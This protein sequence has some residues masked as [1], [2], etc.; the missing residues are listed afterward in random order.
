MTPLRS[1]SRSGGVVC[2]ISMKAFVLSLFLLT[3]VGGA[4]TQESDCFYYYNPA[5][6]V[7]YRIPSTSSLCTNS[8][9]AFQDW[10]SNGRRWRGNWTFDQNRK[11]AILR[12]VGSDPITLDEAYATSLFDQRWTVLPGDDLTP[13][14]SAKHG[15]NL[16][17]EKDTSTSGSITTIWAYYSFLTR[18]A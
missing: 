1:Q 4:A 10:D 9:F 17:K 2:V 13:S 3:L 16:E 14:F 15:E 18:L 6:L 7:V 5:S 12:R 8:S 11:T